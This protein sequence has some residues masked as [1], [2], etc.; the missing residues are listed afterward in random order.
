MQNS[1]CDTHEIA[2]KS[3]QNYEKCKECVA[4]AAAECK[5]CRNLFCPVHIWIDSCAACIKQ[6]VAKDLHKA[7]QKTTEKLLLEL[8]QLDMRRYETKL[9]IKHAASKIAKFESSLKSRPSLG[10]LKKK[11]SQE[12]ESNKLLIITTENLKKALKDLKTSENIAT[13]SVSK[14][15][16]YMESHSAESEALQSEE[17]LL[18]FKIDQLKSQLL[19]SIPYINLRAFSCNSCTVK[20]KSKFHLQLLENLA[21]EDSLFM[22]SLS[23]KKKSSR[24]LPEG[25]NDSCNCVIM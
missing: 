6:E 16:N 7:K 8:N 13:V 19:K 22:S 3:M 14:T 24:S 5:D 17:I 23:V 11:I 4:P 9:Q 2:M 18:L 1:E 21:K 20:I 15:D 25:K 10:K 12:I